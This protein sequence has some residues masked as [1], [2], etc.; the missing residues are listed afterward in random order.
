MHGEVVSRTALTIVR[1]HYDV[2]HIYGQTRAELMF[3]T[4]YAGAEDRLFLMDVLRHSA[5]AQLSS[6]AGGS[7]AN[8]AM[9]ETQWSIA[10]YTEADLQS[11]IDAAP[12]LYGGAGTQLIG[13]A[14]SYVDGINAYIAKAE[15]P[16]FTA[17][18]LPSEYVATGQLPQPWKLTDV[19]AEAS[20]IGGIFG[21][22]GGNE[23]NAA[24]ALQAFER[25]FGR[26]SGRQ[27]WS[28]LREANDPEAPRRSPWPALQGRQAP[29]SLPRGAA[30]IAG[31]RAEGHPSA[32]LRRHL[33]E[34][35]RAGVRGPEHL[36][37]RV[38]DHDSAV[39]LP[40]PPDLP[41]GGHPDA[42]VA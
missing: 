15:N 30:V 26:R 21:K 11:Q 9:D 36:H 41:A 16:L 12:R 25:R 35:S 28:D 32:A 24:L 22:G 18:L 2:P 40:E 4:G 13:D 6:F 29:G 39:P 5:R 33:P 31:G 7:P 19:I 34:R 1:D 3:G 37:L 42:S 17:T 38:R 14:Q 10:P 8:R 27:A 20:L 23:L